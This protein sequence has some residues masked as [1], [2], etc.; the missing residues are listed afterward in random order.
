[1]S[2]PSGQPAFDSITVRACW[3]VVLLCLLL[4]STPAAELETLPYERGGQDLLQTP[5]GG[6][7]TVR[8]L[9]A[10]GEA[11]RFSDVPVMLIRWWTD[12]CP[13][14]EASL[15]ALEKLRQRYADRGL[16]VVGIY[17]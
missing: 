5:F 6:L 9:T 15:P 13:Y 11:L 2:N 3:G 10:G 14:C 8:W 1:M 16:V 7:G 12:T 4:G 17:H